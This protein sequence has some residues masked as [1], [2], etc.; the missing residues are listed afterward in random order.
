MVIPKKYHLSVL[1]L[2][3]EG[4]PGITR[5]KSLARLHVWWL[6]INVD[7][8]QTVQSCCN[9]QEAARNAVRV[10]T[11]SSVGHSSKSLAATTC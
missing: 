8:E 5:M 6:T 9:C 11:S 4:Y 3:H 7:I 1:K 10:R 2:L